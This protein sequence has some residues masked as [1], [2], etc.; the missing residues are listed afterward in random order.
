MRLAWFLV[1]ALVGFSADRVKAQG[2]DLSAPTGGRSAL[3]GSTGVALAR[4]GAAPF[5]NP[6][7]IVRIRD[8]RLAFSVNFYALSLVHFTDFHQ[9][10]ALDETLFGPGSSGDSGLLSSTFR[11]LPS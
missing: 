4:D 1:L 10:D 5:F 8:E 2:N 9:P 6:A 11:V 3:M 7:T